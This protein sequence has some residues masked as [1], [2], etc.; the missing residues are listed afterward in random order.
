MATLHHSPDRL[1]KVTTGRMIC[2]L[3]ASLSTQ[4]PSFTKEIKVDFVAQSRAGVP[5]AGPLGGFR[6]FATLSVAP[7]GFGQ[8]HEGRKTIIRRVGSG[9]G[10]VHRGPQRCDPASRQA[11]IP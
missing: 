1:D 2:P 7:P 9:V 8:F 6:I 4:N 3:H 10:I 5:S 11:K